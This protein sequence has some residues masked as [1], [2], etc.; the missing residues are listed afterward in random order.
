M[1]TTVRSCNLYSACRFKPLRIQ[2]QDDQFPWNKCG[3]SKLGNVS[4]MY[5]DYKN[6]T[7]KSNHLYLKLLP[8]T[9]IAV[10][11]MEDLPP[12]ESVVRK[13]TD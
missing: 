6:S 10:R 3:P 1:K 7:V 9:H 5:R 11:V 12:L 8:H 4:V 2:R 13:W